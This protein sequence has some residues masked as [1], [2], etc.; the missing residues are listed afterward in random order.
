MKIPKTILISR[1]DNIGD[2]VLTLPM[3]GIIKK[4]F[5]DI[6]IGFLGRAYTKDIIESCVFVDEFIDFNDFLNKSV[7]ICGKRIEAIIHVLPDP[8]IAK[9]AFFLAIPQ[10]IGTTNRIYHWLYCNKLIRL[11]RKN[12]DLHEAQLNLKLLS[13][14][15][16]HQ[17]FSFP[18]IYSSYGFCASPALPESLHAQISKDKFNVIFHP[19]SKGNGKEWPLEHYIALAKLLDKDK[20]NVFITG[21]KQEEPKLEILFSQIGDLV[22]N[23]CGKL[24]LKVFVSFIANCDGLVASGTGPIHVAAAL[25]IHALGIFPSIK[26][27]HPGRW[28]PIG[29]NAYTFCNQTECNLCKKQISCEC[30]QNIEPNAIA[31][32]LEEL[33]LLKFPV[34]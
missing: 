18:E 21:T 17:Q 31:K 20:F 3:A 11:S 27:I 7:S 33:Y 32:K 12:S 19:K 5:P 6:L 28:Q 22:I 24:S 13:C 10:R 9:R 15:S 14:L 26:P 4:Y 29:Q 1:T 2:V 30:M 23:L 8:V 16:I 34:K 25:R